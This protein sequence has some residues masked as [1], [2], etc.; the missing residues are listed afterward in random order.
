MLGVSNS[1]TFAGLAY[2][3]SRT[4]LKNKKVSNSWTW[5]PT[6]FSRVTM[7]QP[8]G[9]DNTTWTKIIET[10]SPSQSFPT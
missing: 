3:S 9:H 5:E 4:S 1:G 8:V 2:T 10:I 6:L 7:G